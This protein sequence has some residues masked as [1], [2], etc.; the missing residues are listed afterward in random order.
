MIARPRVPDF[1][2]AMA[3]VGA[4]VGLLAARGTAAEEPSWQ[5]AL[6]QRIAGHSG[7]AGVCVVHLES[8]TRFGHRA[9]VPMPT[10]SLIKLPVM[11]A[12]YHAAS[13]GRVKLSDS[14]V[15]R[16][17]DK[18]PGSGILTA[19]FSAGGSFPLRD[20]VRLMIAWSDNTATNLVID[21]IGL[22]ATTA[23][24]QELGCPNTHL[25]AKV[26]RR[27][28]SIE[29]ERSKQFGLGSTTA[30]EM[31]KLL[32]RLQRRELVSLA[33]SD[34][35]L[36]HLAACQDRDTFP[37]HLPRGTMVAH[38]TGLVT[39]VRTDAGIITSK[40]GTILLCVLTNNN[41]RPGGAAEDPGQAL[42]ADVAKIVFQHYNGSAAADAPTRINER[43][44]ALGDSGEDVARL[45]RALN[46]ALRP[47]PEL[48]VDGEFGP[49]TQTALLRWQRGREL[50]VDG[51]FL[52]A[53][54][55]LV[56]P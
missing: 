28:T 54:W 27:D 34:E 46:R 42:C 2:P 49:A 20:A 50:P 53:W 15:L 18:V 41:R 55:Q 32:E 38:K 33:A 26:F 1:V 35:M 44:L 56:E 19:H 52:P 4:A 25:H 22:P 21:K 43:R 16:E 45:Q 24:M 17:E 39:G 37:K 31:V 14:V 40:G 3:A 51:V 36:A 8:Q 10:A 29:P 5:A 48:D 30:A 11:I 47:S 7:D 9:D 12:A 6:T 13:L 23:L